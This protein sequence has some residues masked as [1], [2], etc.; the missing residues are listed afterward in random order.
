MAQIVPK[1]NLN[2]TPA[3]AENNSLIFAKNI[4]LDVDGSIHRD[5]GVMPMSIHKGNNTN[6]LVNYDNI[7]NRII[8]DIKKD[9]VINPQIGGHYNIIL[10]ELETISGKFNSSAISDNKFKIVGIISNSNEFYIFIYGS[11]KFQTGETSRNQ[12]YS[13]IIKYDEKLDKFTPCNCNWKWSG[14]K[15]HGCVINNLIGDVILNI[16]EYDT[17]ETVPIKSINLTNSDISDD[18]SIYTQTPNIPIT[19]IKYGGN[20]S[21][22]IPNGVY[23]FFI[24]YKIRKDFYTNWFPASSEI[25]SGNK[26]TTITSFGSL[27]YVNTHRD[28]D[29]SFI[30]SIEHLINN[31]KR[32]YKEFQIGFILSHDDAIY[33]RAWKH[34]GFDINS[35]NFDYKAEDAEEIEIIDLLKSTYGLYNVGNIASFKN[36]LYISNYTETDFNDPTLQAIANKVVIDIKYK[37]GGEGYDGRTVVKA[38]VAGQ[39]VISGLVV[40][41]VNKTFTGDNGIFKEI[42]NTSGISGVNSAATAIKNALKNKTGASDLQYDTPELYGIDI[43]TE[44]Q[45]LANAKESLTKKYERMSTSNVN[46]EVKFSDNTVQELIIN[47]KKEPSLYEGWE[48]KV[49]PYIYNIARYLNKRCEWIDSNGAKNETCVIEIGRKASVIKTIYSNP[50]FDLITKKNNITITSPIYYQKITI[51]F[52]AESSKY[53]TNTGADLT[54]FSTLIPYQKYKFYMHFVK[55]NGE[56]T[57]GYYCGKTGEI[58]APYMQSCTSVIYP[59][60]NNINIPEGYN[61][62]FFSII[63]TQIN[64]ATVFNIEQGYNANQKEA[65]CLELSMMLMPTNKN[66]HIKQGGDPIQSGILGPDTGIPKTVEENEINANADTPII[67]PSKKIVQTYTGKYYDSA[68]T[69]FNRYFGADGIVVF[70]KGD[71]SNGK[72]G[73]VI[74]DYKLAENE[75][76]ELIKCTPYLNKTNLKVSQ[77]DSLYFNDYATMNLL[78]FICAVTPL[79]KERCINNYTDGSSVYYKDD[80]SINNASSGGQDLILTE[81]SKYNN[82]VTSSAIYKLKNFNLKSS[83]IV[84]IYS[85][86]NLNYV[87]LS[88]EPKMSIKTWY[89]REA[90]STSS[91]T[92]IDQNNSHN[93]LLRLI[94]SQLMSTIYTLPTMYKTYTRKV[95]YPYSDNNITRFDNTVR[96]SI[97]YGDENKINVLTFDANDYYNI[98]TNRGKIINMISVGDSILVHTSDSMF[99]FSG[100]NT[101]QSSDGEIQTTESKPFDTGVSEVFGSDFGF[102]G[103]QN[104]DDHIVTENGYIFFD[105]DSR[106]VYMYSGQG[107]IIKL[108]DSVEKLFRCKEISNINFAND[109]YNNRFFMSINF[110]EEYDTTVDDKPTVKR[111]YYPVTLSF[112]FSEQSKSFVSLHDFYYQKAFNTKTKCYF[113]TSDSKDISTIDKTNTGCYYKLEIFPD[114]IYPQKC[115]IVV[116]HLTDTDT[117]NATES[118][119]ISISKCFSVIDIIDNTNFENIKT[120]NAV[121]WCGNKIISEFKDINFKQPETLRMAEDINNEIAC[122]YIMIY[123]DTCM[124]NECDCTKRANDK[125]ISSLISYQYPFFNQGIWTYNYFRNILNSKGNT[126][127]Y[128]G[129][130]NSLIEGKY[131]VV[132]FMFDDNFK[133]ETLTL[134]YNIKS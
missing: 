52:K 7:I 53:S 96:S 2:K 36:K 26:N 82:D 30:L 111:K 94:P 130:N 117:S 15:I 6:L 27:S 34:F 77:Y 57:N 51:T 108:S 122:R 86:F 64:S 70:D 68:D 1:L 74:N 107:R 48:D 93:I 71:F 115:T 80:N 59:Q 23:Q 98:P 61:A 125:P 25:F 97:P 9:L 66:L 95:Y 55:S 31:N 54:G 56:I 18:E 3:L 90:D 87:A 60:F 88:E 101:I 83:S 119:S 49:V 39:E 102:A 124:T 46:Y 76:T 42:L 113:L 81:L 84:Y 106:I 89:D 62:C 47:G 40:D 65:S 99:R 29:N 118:A 22:V 75:T 121:N 12:A 17:I 100:S 120:L 131:F 129:D 32:Y 4:R 73:Y 91:T 92:E 105:R 110:Y 132:R 10:R 13:N 50:D 72:L 126:T 41:N 85:Q 58:Q 8:S 24:R 104:K 116:K 33:A 35:I 45:T 78:G 109:Y 127:S 14:G 44:I 67:N 133:F 134:N 21:Y 20:F 128:S 123:T 38:D 28:S 103:I 79:D 16:G 63:H 114:Y 69:T 112:N 19:N 11:V 43:I 37:E 5:Y